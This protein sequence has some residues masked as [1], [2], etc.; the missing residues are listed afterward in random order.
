MTVSHLICD[1]FGGGSWG[2]I[3]QGA[4]GLGKLALLRRSRGPAVSSLKVAHNVVMVCGVVV[5][6][7]RPFTKWWSQQF[8]PKGTT[9]S[10]KPRTFV[11]CRWKIICCSASTFAW[12]DEFREAWEVSPG[13][14]VVM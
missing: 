2:F 11:A 6:F 7:R 9:G 4:A 12:E 3:E 1:S 5:G 13:S 10:F 14:C 8:L